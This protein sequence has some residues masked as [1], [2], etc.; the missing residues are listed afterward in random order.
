LTYLYDVALEISY[1]DGR[2]ETGVRQ[3]TAVSIDAAGI[4]VWSILAKFYGERA[5]EP[6]SAS[7][8][9]SPPFPRHFALRT[10]I[11]DY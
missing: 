7:E 10:F 9:L 2:G 1:R 11:T 4:V 3:G 8:R 5:S 6:T